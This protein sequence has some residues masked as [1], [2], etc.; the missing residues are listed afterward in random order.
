MN[1]KSLEENLKKSS[2]PFPTEMCQFLI[3]CAFLYFVQWICCAFLYFA[4][5]ICCVCVYVVSERG[6]RG[7]GTTVF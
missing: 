6:I 7:L 1:P 5:Q 2:V 3:R 4:Q